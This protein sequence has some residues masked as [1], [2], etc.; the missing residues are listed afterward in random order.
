MR[1]MSSSPKKVAALHLDEDD[2]L[3][4][5]VGATMSDAEPDVDRLPG[6]DAMIGAIYR[7]GADTADDVPVLRSASMGLVAEAFTGV[8]DDALDLV[9]V[10]VREDRV[11][12]HG[13]S[14]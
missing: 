5:V 2:V 14:S 10:L 8:H 1:T 11:V 7:H 9:V 13:R 4:A 6:P 3:A 12:A